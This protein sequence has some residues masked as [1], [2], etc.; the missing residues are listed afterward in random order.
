MTRTRRHADQHAPQHRAVA[1][2]VKQHAV[3]FP[4][5]LPPCSNAPTCIRIPYCRQSAMPH[6]GRFC[7]TYVERP[8]VS[9]LARSRTTRTDHKQDHTQDIC[10]ACGRRLRCECGLYRH[11]RL[12]RNSA[13]R[14]SPRSGRE[15][16]IICIVSFEWP[17][18]TAPS[19][20]IANFGP[21]IKYHTSQKIN[22]NSG[23]SRHGIKK[24][25]R[26]SVLRRT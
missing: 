16:M 1:S 19:G 17:S 3:T 9:D 6:M 8:A 2:I 22:L 20:I 15:C 12:A 11:S 4:G 26:A 24:K 18:D 14:P 13:A 23:C 25:G 10:E 5:R 7:K 21:S